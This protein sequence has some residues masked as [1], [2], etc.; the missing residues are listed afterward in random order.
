MLRAAE[1]MKSTRKTDDM[2]VSIEF[3][4]TPPRAAPVGG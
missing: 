1:V 4:G 2:G 3:V